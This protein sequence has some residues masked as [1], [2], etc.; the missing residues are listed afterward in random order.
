MRREMRCLSGV[1]PQMRA[2]GAAER[3]VAVE[4]G[5]VGAVGGADEGGGR[6]LGG[7]RSDAS[8]A[9]EREEERGKGREA[10]G[11]QVTQ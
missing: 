9:A 4:V 7:V 3:D 2:A 8:G 5:C 1:A 11:E 10:H 6:R